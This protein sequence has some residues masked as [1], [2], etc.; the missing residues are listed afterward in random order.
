MIDRRPLAPVF[1]TTASSAM[2]YSASREKLSFTCQE[3]D[4]SGSQRR[5]DM[6]SRRS[7]NSHAL[8]TFQGQKSWMQATR[9]ALW[10][11]SRRAHSVFE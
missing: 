10:T 5:E 4:T 8:M 9:I 11:K 1:C 2:A 6:T 7:D 3:Q